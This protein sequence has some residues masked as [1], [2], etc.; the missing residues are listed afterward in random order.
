MTAVKRECP[1]P[2]G[3]HQHGHYLAYERDHCRCFPCRLAWSQA[4]LAYNATGSYLT[5]SPRFIPRHGTDRRIQALLALGWRHSDITARLTEI[6]PLAATQSDQLLRR[7]GPYVWASTAEAVRAVYDQLAMI[8]GPSKRN[9]DRARKLG[10]VPP[11]AWDDDELDDPEAEPY[12]DTINHGTRGGYN[13]HR[14][15]GQEACG[16]CL[17]A[18]RSYQ[19]ERYRRTKGAA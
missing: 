4:R 15:R 8:P 5:S 16:A 9:R 10:Y 18:E 13:Q 6:D 12:R 19:A 2:R 11:L 1:H 17:A 7:P 3:R 14:N